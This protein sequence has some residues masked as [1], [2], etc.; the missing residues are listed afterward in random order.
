M[1]KNEAIITYLLQC[2]AIQNSP[3]YFNFINA[4][5]DNKQIVTQANDKIIDKPF[6]DGSIQKR[7]TFTI[8]DYKSIAYTAVVKELN[9]LSATLVYPNENLEDIIDVQGIIDWISE[10]EVLRNYPDFGEDCVIDDIKA[11]SDNPNLNS[12]DTSTNPPLAKYSIS[13]QINYVDYSKVL[14]N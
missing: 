2:P 14:F 11:L 3:L 8:M 13:I 5:D 10:Q 9:N 1:D 6:I 12:V 4:K 7:F